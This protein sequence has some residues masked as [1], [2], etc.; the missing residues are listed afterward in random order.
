MNAAS[1]RSLSMT[2]R[3]AAPV[4]LVGRTPQELGRDH[5]M[6]VGEDVGRHRNGLAQNPLHRE[7]SVVHR[8]RDLVDDNARR[9]QRDL[10]QLILAATA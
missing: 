10:Q 9:L 3:H 7:A 6:A 8:R 2:H 1:Q 5:V 4:G